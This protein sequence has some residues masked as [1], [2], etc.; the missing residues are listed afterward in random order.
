MSLFEKIKKAVEEDPENSVT[1]D[2]VEKEE[3]DK[4]EGFIE[5]FRRVVEDDDTPV[6]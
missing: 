4:M 2:D 6:N 1:M 5:H 3:R